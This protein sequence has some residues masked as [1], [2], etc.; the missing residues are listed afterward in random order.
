VGVYVLQLESC[1]LSIFKASFDYKIQND[2]LTANLID[3]TY[4][5]K[6][7]ESSVAVNTSFGGNLTRNN[8]LPFWR[9]NSSYLNG[10]I[11]E[12]ASTIIQHA[13]QIVKV[14]KIT[15]ESF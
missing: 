11:G 7:K 12:T 13:T 10:I 9:K 8:F 15:R 2:N 14:I 5:S 6:A 3:N 1:V 4:V